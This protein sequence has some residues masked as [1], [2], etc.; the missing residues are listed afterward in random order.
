MM[1]GQVASLFELTR[2]GVV[3]SRHFGA[4][5]I[6]DAHGALQYSLGDP[7]G[8]AFLRSSAKPF[9]A[10][11][12]FEQGGPETFDLNPQERALICASH[13][14]SDEH[15]LIAGSIQ[16]KAGLRESDLR[17]GIHMPGDASAYRALIARGELPTPNRN[18]C[19]GKHSGM[20]AFAKMRGLPLETYLEMDHPI[21]QDIL[22]AFSEISRCPRERIEIGI[23][24]CSAPNFAVPLF[25]AALAY[26][27]LCD[28]RDFSEKRQQAARGITSAMMGQPEMVS[29]SEEFDCRLMR[30]G[31]GKFVCKRGAEGYQAIGL[32]PGTLSEDSPGV[33]IAFKVS[34]GDLSFRTIDTVPH[35]RVRPAVTLEILR[36]IGALDDD[37]LAELA[38][39]G[40]V[41]PVH[42]LRGLLVGTS[43]PAFHL[44]K[45]GARDN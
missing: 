17:C 35:N 23:D 5:A 7:N 8:V 34:D 3:E 32:M 40:P 22:T 44:V 25:N 18:N 12:F 11:P 13:E 38:I 16:A 27:R 14:G 41:L 33:G 30:T 39:F 19:S 20:L 28:P 37:E 42:N 24:G 6:A 15:V 4:I 2:G 29:G 36:Q 10:L 21:Q 31:R 1:H 45:A 9:Q 26:A 43:R